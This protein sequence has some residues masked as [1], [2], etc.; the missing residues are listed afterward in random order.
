MMGGPSIS[1]LSASGRWIPP[2]LA[3]LS[4]AILCSGL[5]QGMAME[6]IMERAARA[7]SIAVGRMGAA[8]SIP[9]ADEVSAAEG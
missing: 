3:I 8:D 1:P 6:R 4:P 7:S 2:Q 5:A 9:L